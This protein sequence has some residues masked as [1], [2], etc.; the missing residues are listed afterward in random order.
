M[1]HVVLHR[2]PRPN[3]TLGLCSTC[4]IKKQ[5]VTRKLSTDA[6]LRRNGSNSSIKGSIFLLHALHTPIP[7]ASQLL[8]R[9]TRRSRTTICRYVRATA[10]HYTPIHHQP[11]ASLTPPGLRPA[12]DGDRAGR[13]GL[14]HARHVVTCSD[15]CDARKSSSKSA[16]SISRILCRSSATC[17]SPRVTSPTANASSVSAFSSSYCSRISSP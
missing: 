15:Y 13:P 8:R 17:S 12:I 10:G 6:P 7:C 4:S 16:F 1:L 11:P 2:S 14:P 3:V 9:S 5:E